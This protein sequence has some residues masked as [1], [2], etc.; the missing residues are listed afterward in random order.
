MVCL[1]GCAVVGF[2]TAG[3]E[4]GNLEA[5]NLVNPPIAIPSFSLITERIT[6][7]Y[8]PIDAKNVKPASYLY[9]IFSP[10]Y[11]L[12]SC[13]TSFRKDREALSVPFGDFLFFIRR[14]YCRKL[15]AMRQDFSAMSDF[16]QE[17]CSLSLI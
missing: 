15:F 2:G 8:V 11:Q 17:R 6:I 14:L 5:F 12:V 3:D 10:R 16:Q 13:D 7:L 4:S 9:G 1:L